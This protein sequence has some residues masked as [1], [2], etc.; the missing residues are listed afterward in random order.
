M[1]GFGSCS[2]GMD[3]AVAALENQMCKQF[4][5]SVYLISTMSSPNGLPAITLTLKMRRKNEKI[6]TEFLCSVS[7]KDN[8]QN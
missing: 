2:S 7:N 5:S 3:G 4:L 6:L 8:L 1:A